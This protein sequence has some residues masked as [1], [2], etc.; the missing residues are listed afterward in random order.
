MGGPDFSVPPL[1]AILDSPNHRISAVFSSPPKPKGR[2]LKSSPSPVCLLAEKYSLPVY[3]PPSLRS[4]EI[5]D[6]INSIEADIMVVVAYGL[7][8][9]K[10][11][12]WVKKY[13][14]INIHPSDLPKYR[15]AAP[16]Q[17]TIMAGETETAVC[18]IQMD[19]GIDTGD[20]LLKE[21]FGLDP[22]IG[23]RELS[24]RC[25]IRG[26]ALCLKVLDSIGD[27]KRTPQGTDGVSYAEKLTKEEGRIDW[28]MAAAFLERKI[29][30][31][32]PWP[33]A[34]FSYG[35]EDIK[36]L[37]ADFSEETSPYPPGTVIGEKFEIACGEGILSPKKLQRP[38]RKILSVEE[39][40]SGA[41]IP[42]FSV[43]S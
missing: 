30:G 16:L 20:I 23:L 7:I 24:Q 39:F 18:V 15:G 2:G 43:L 1:L 25:S 17:R 21:K 36:I 37:E 35:G 34:Y 10:N 4:P 29:R 22:R 19:E 40:L 42:K 41:G 13:G 6:T 33:G 14:S 8:V 12:L 32:S 38:G 26:A 3:T 27:I 28:K 11:L 5:L 31:T 9:P